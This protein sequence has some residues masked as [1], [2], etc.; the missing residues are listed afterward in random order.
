[1]KPTPGNVVSHRAGRQNSALYPALRVSQP[2]STLFSPAS[3]ETSSDKDVMYR[4]MG[5][6]LRYKDCRD[7]CRDPSGLI[8]PQG[9]ARL[10]PDIRISHSKY[11]QP[12]ENKDDTK[13]KRS[14]D[15]RRF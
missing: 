14:E 10:P 5:S 9:S 12:S 6:A 13:R 15:L 2:R 11:G 8:A 1:M 7:L 4:N 3:V